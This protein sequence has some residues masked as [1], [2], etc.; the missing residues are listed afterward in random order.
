MGKAYEDI[1]DACEQAERD[2]MKGVRE[3]EEEA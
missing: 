2:W 3:D 1:K